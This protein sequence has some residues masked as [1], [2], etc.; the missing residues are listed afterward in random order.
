MAPEE[1]ERLEASS[2]AAEAELKRLLMPRDPLDDRDAV[3]EI[4]A[5]TGGDEAALFAGDLL[6]MY[7]RFAEPGL[8]VE[9]S[10]TPRGRRAGQGGDLRGARRER[11]RR[12]ALRVRGAPRAAR[13]RDREPGP[14]PHLG[15][16]GRRPARGRGGGRADQRQR[17][18][19]RRLPLLRPGRPVGEH[20]RLGRAHHPPADGL[21]VTCQDEKSQHKNKDKAMGVLRSRLLDL[22]IAEQEAERARDRKL[23]VGTGDRSAKIRTYN[24]PQSRVTDHRIGYTTHALQQV[25]DGDLDELIE[26]LRLAGQE[27]R[28]AD[29]PWAARGRRR[30]SA[31]T[32]TASGPGRADPLDD[33][34]LAGKGFD[35]AAAERRA[36]ARRCA[37]PEAARPVPAVRPAARPRSS[38]SSRRGCGG[39]RGASRCSTSRDRDFRELS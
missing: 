14:H 33:G 28:A 5:G 16:D 20:H 19:D 21:V 3:V 24:F 31:S 35:D 27:E 23:Q 17:S 22:R 9:L 6:R 39:V 37:R 13:A 36:A 25:L 2:R 34:Y 11:V 4:R 1:A 18:E 12:P 29:R 15:R 8:A 32:W 7:T 10:A 38:R 30:S 26:R